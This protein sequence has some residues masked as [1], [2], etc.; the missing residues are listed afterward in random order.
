MKVT[1]IFGCVLGLHA[2]IIAVLLMQ[3]G[4]QTSQPPTQTHTQT[5]TMSSSMRPTVK[6]ASRTSGEMIPA[7]RVGGLDS[8]FNAGIES[9]PGTRSFAPIDT[10]EP[11]EPLSR[12][13]SFGSPQAVTVD[14]AGAGFE[15][16]TVKRGDSLWSISRNYNVSLNELY[17]ANGLS[18]NSV[19]RVGQQIQIPVEGGSVAIQPVTPEVYQPSRMNQATT[20]YTVKR[21]DNLSRIASQF[22]T[23]VGAIK[24]ANSKTSDVIRVGETLT[25]PVGASAAANVGSTPSAGARSG[26]SATVVSSVPRGETQT[27]I[28]KSGEFPARIARQ[29][30]MTTSELLSINNISDPRK[31]RVGQELIVSASGSSSNVDSRIETVAAPAPT[32]PSTPPRPARTIQADEDIIVIEADPLIEGELTGVGEDDAFENAIEVPVIRLEE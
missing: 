29:Y 26:V 30:G 15:T 32:P 21:G 14:V 20:T 22:D 25:V 24:A 17:A 8:A 2:G 1:K 5:S 16:Y 31:L 12:A 28:V 13:D 27:H 3:P 11:L 10:S 9:D 6:G 18:K 7:T 19:L 4:C 23:T